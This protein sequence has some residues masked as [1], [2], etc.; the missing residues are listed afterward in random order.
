MT[1]QLRTRI[2]WATVIAVLFVG[3][4]MVVRLNGPATGEASP[5]GYSH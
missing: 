3:V 2:V 5:S 4:Y 1:R